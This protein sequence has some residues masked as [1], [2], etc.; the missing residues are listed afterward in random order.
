MADITK[1]VI[2]GSS[3]YGPADEAYEDKLTLDSESIRYEYK[4]VVE[5]ERNP[6]RKWSYKTTSPIFRHVFL[7]AVDDM[8]DIMNMDDDAFCTDIGGIEFIVTFDDKTRWQKIFWLPG[9]TFIDLFAVIS[10]LIPDSEYKP[11]VLLT[12][13]DFEDLEEE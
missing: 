1:I 4:P 6:Y 5:S 7:Q 8:N 11:A 2:K 13:E 12:S 3:G 10:K 9:D